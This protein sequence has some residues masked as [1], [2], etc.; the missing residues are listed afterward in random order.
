VLAQHAAKDRVSITRGREDG[1][2]KMPRRKSELKAMMKKAPQKSDVP[3][4]ISAE[5]LS[6]YADSD[7]NKI[8]E[9]TYTYAEDKEE[10]AQNGQRV[11]GGDALMDKLAGGPSLKGVAGVLPIRVRVPVQGQLIRFSKDLAV[12]NKSI[13]LELYHVSSGLIKFLKLILL[14]VFLLV[15]YRRRKSIVNYLIRI[16]S[17]ILPYL[18]W[19]PK[20]KTPF[21]MMLT[22]LVFCVIFSYISPT[23]W[24]AFALLAYIVALGRWILNL[25]RIPQGGNS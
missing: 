23:K 20:M 15:I 17:F 2:K 18:N 24:L 19:T 7:P 1:A 8:L 5:L 10:A 21:G 25:I 14:V 16:K 4:S 9:R 11:F 22:C 13:Q 6:E 3:M 12:E